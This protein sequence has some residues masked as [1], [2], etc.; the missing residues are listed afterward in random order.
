MTQKRPG[1][2]PLR[3]RKRVTCK[4]A[5]A[6][7]AQVDYCFACWPG[8]P[9]APP[10]C[11]RC[12]S[13]TNYYTS[14]MCRR[15]H[16]DGNPGVESY[17]DCHAWGVGRLHD[18]LCAGCNS[19]RRE[20]ATI[21]ACRI[22]SNVLTLGKGGVCRLCRKQGTLMREGKELLDI[23]AANAHGQQL[24]FADMFYVS[25]RDRAKPLRPE[26]TAVEV[27][28]TARAT[29]HHVQLRLFDAQ[30]DLATHGREN[31]IERC[32][33]II[34]EWV[35]REVGEHARRHGWTHKAMAEIRSGIRIVIGLQDDPGA[36]IKA[37]D[38]TLLGGIDL[39]VRRILDVLAEMRL[40]DEDR[41]PA[42]ETGFA[43]RA[44]ELPAPMRD[45]LGI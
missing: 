41:T 16:R 21:A 18:W 2:R 17:R 1:A 14:G 9:V 3:R 40:L 29:V 13:R 28:P 12:G 39:P 33:P 31:L 25:A 27:R 19:W 11:L 20:H 10:P 37:T 4:L 35:D 44:A 5:P 43:Q 36:P 30:R 34:A 42:V 23:R 32:D 45:E 24:F 15:C 7:M 6:A 38:V 26:T 22:C 8:G